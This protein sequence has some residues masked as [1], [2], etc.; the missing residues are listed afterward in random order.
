LI[1]TVYQYPDP[2]RHGDAIVAAVR[3]NLDTSG[4]SPAY[5]HHRKNFGAR[6]GK[7]VA[8]FLNRTAAAFFGACHSSHVSS[9][10]QDASRRAA[11]RTFRIGMIS[12][13]NR[14]PL[15]RIMLAH[16][17]ERAGTRRGKDPCPPAASA[18]DDPPC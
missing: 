18:S 12:S 10:S 11:V 13:E 8:G 5:L 2:D 17:R 9:S 16:T 6:A 4:K 1:I 7:L 15:F 3:F 14:F